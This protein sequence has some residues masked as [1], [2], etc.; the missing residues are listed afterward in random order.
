[1][2]KS[3][4][5]LSEKFACFQHVWFFRYSLMIPDVCSSFRVWKMV[6]LTGSWCFGNPKML[7][8]LLMM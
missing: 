5:K 6:T 2:K 4:K 1:L 7:G 3:R 8:R